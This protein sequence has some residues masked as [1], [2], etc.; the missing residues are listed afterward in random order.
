MSCPENFIYS[1]RGRQGIG[2]I[3]PQSGLDYPLVSPSAD[4]RY[5]LADLYFE[6]DD[7]GLYGIGPVAQHP[8]R[9]KWLYGLGCEENSAIPGM[10]TPAHAADIVIVDANNNIVFDSTNLNADVNYRRFSVKDWG[11]DYTL[12][13]WLSRDAV[14]RIVAH[15]N[16]SPDEAAPVN[17]PIHLA[18]DNAIIDERAVYKMP[19]RVKSL[20]VLNSTVRRS[21]VKF[22][23][24]YNVDLI[25]AAQEVVGFRNQ[26]AITINVTDTA[27]YSDCAEDKTPNIYSINGIRANQFGQFFITADKC[28]FSRVPTVKNDDDTVSRSKV[29]GNTPIAIDSNCP[30]CCDCADYVNMALYMNRVRNQYSRVGRRSHQVKLLHED[31]IARWLEQRTCRLNKPL[32]LSLSPLSCPYMEVIMQFCNQCPDCV[33]DVVLSVT[34]SSAPDGAVGTVVPGY[35][36]IN[37]PGLPNETFNISGTW[38]TFS[39]RVGFVDKGSSVFV[40]F[41][42]K[43]EPR[44]YPY[45]ITG[46]LTGTIGGQPIK[47]CDPKYG[48]DEIIESVDTRA[49]YCNESGCT[50]VFQQELGSITATDLSAIQKIDGSRVY[51]LTATASNGAT[52]TYQWQQTQDGTTW[53]NLV[54]ADLS[55]DGAQTKT[56]TLLQTYVSAHPTQEYRVVA[57]A[58][59]AV[60][61][62]ITPP[63]LTQEPGTITVTT[64]TTQTQQNGDKTYSVTATANNNAVL[65]YQWEYADSTTW[66]DITNA[67]TNTL[68]IS[69]A[70]LSQHPNR[71]YR[72]RITGANTTTLT[73]NMASAPPVSGNTIWARGTNTYGELGQGN[74]NFNL[75]AVTV[76]ANSNWS[77][78]SAHTQH[79]LAI[80]TAGEIYSWGWNS[81]GQVGIG[82][83]SNFVATPTRVGLQSNW[84]FVS[85]GNQ[86]SLAINANGELWGWGANFWGQL[87]DNTTIDRYVPIRIG[88]ATNWIYAAAGTGASFAINA[89][90]ELWSWGDNTKGLLGVGDTTNRLT[91]TKINTTGPWTKVVAHSTTAIA[92]TSNNDAYV[93]GS[94]AVGA[95]GLNLSVTQFKTT[96][97]LLNHVVNG[98]PLKWSDVSISENGLAITVD[99]KLYG[100]GKNNMNQVGLNDP[101]PATPSYYGT[102]QLING[103]RGWNK[104]Y[105][106]SE[107]SLALANDG[108]AYGF[109]FFQLI[110]RYPVPTLI[111]SGEQF[112]QL[113]AGATFAAGITS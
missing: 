69:A 54:D 29:N 96:P 1:P 2:V 110:G 68:T 55:I 102:P 27:E 95:L 44:N 62:Q 82:L 83:P 35:T 109:G 87:G 45:A 94:N 65:A 13:E 25:T 21:A 7:P 40:R 30:A 111:S 11:A 24:G 60:T 57:R 84:V 52:V 100:W 18:P 41:S 91:P 15:K 90:G 39:T 66:A 80:N 46:T 64:S 105:A 23:D 113:A 67:T 106:S 59:N 104:V 12:Y 49:L 72:V 37:A 17:Y 28:I 89:N 50:D 78:I 93:W 103:T 86:H 74:T 4:I 31:N 77:A 99:G 19:Q 61:R 112:N 81:R 58:N 9:I 38:P 92:L 76:G 107:W 14:C 33:E 48:S 8:L 6:Y 34:L 98:S 5:L 32:R 101:I 63:P 43:F 88:A 16:W 71:K 22:K 79:T 75:N 36:V 26:T 10:P 47:P 73:Y 70:N 108:G 3:Q 20:T 85:A 42:L 97:T 56:L 53:T 51:S